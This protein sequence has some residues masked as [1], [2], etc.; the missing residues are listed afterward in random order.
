MWDN[1]LRPWIDYWIRP[2]PTHSRESISCHGLTGKQL[3]AVDSLWATLRPSRSL[4]FDEP[5]LSHCLHLRPIHKHFWKRKGILY[6]LVMHADQGISVVV[7]PAGLQEDT[8][9]VAQLP[10]QWQ[11]EGDNILS[12]LLVLAKLVDITRRDYRRRR[13]LITIVAQ[14]AFFSRQI[15]RDFEAGL[16][17][18]LSMA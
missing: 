16:S 6:F 7:G 12:G 4:P 15:L 2:L 14:P 17:P 3:V 5:Y 9:L 10:P 8:L 1:L 13:G 18:V 11:H